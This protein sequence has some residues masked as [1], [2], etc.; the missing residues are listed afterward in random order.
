[1]TYFDRLRE[2]IDYLEGRVDIYDGQHAKT[3]SAWDSAWNEM[4]WAGIKPDTAAGVKK[5]IRDN[6]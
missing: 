5:Y 3:V 6:E 4:V 2:V 1:M